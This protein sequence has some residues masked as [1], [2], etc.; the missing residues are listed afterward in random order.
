MSGTAGIMIIFQYSVDVAIVYA[1]G[2]LA[3]FVLSLHRH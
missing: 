1:S 3:L 2:N